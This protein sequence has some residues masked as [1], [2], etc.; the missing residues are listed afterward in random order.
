MTT[1]FFS[2]ACHS[3]QAWPLY[4]FSTIENTSILVENCGKKYWHFSTNW[5]EGLV[6][7]ARL[8]FA[9]SSFFSGRISRMSKWGGK[10]GSDGDLTFWK[11]YTSFPFPPPNSTCLLPCRYEKKINCLSSSSFSR[12]FVK[13]RSEERVSYVGKLKSVA[14]NFFCV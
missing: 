1:F 2:F 11:R 9:F 12:A 10:H 13:A 3:I 6:M 4:T 14:I 7:D 8:I 5:S